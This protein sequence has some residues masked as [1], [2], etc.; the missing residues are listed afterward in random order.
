MFR[1]ILLSVCLL[2][3]GFVTYAPS[4]DYEFTI[5]G[6]EFDLDVKV[7]VT[8]DLDYAVKYVHENLDS[9]AEIGDF[10][11]RGVT[12]PS[13]DG[14][15]P[16]VWL[17]YLDD[18]PVIQ[19]ELLHATFDIMRWANVPLTEETEE[20]YTYELQYLTKQFND[21]TQ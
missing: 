2:V 14:K 9:T 16:I 10:D 18:K 3:I 15:S 21:K 13:K 5:P 19:H 6:G 8:A 12:F 11:A 1:I 17:P 20:V 4:K 7:L